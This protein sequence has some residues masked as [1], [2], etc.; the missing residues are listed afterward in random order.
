MLKYTLPSPLMQNI[1]EDISLS[2]LERS[3]IYI[4]TPSYVKIYNFL[5]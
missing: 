4:H 2:I 5:S 3:L 1:L